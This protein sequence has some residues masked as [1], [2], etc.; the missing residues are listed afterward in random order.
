MQV[1]LKRERFLSTYLSLSLCFSHYYSLL[2]LCLPLCRPLSTSSSLSLTL[3]NF[4]LSLTLSLSLP[5]SLSLRL[6]LS[7]YLYHSPYHYHSLS[8]SLLFVLLSFITLFSSLILK[9]SLNMQTLH[10]LKKCFCRY[11]ELVCLRNPNEIF[12]TLCT[13]KMWH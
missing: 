1:Q 2:Y 11:L 7:L 12:I 9:I 13:L 8:C 3:V 5:L 6:Y 4:S 10:S